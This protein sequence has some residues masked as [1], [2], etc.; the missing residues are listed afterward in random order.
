MSEPLSGLLQ[1]RMIL[2]GVAAR[3]EEKANEG[4]EARLLS[5][6]KADSIIDF[7][8]ALRDVASFFK[9]ASLC[10]KRQSPAG[11]AKLLEAIPEKVKKVEQHC[12]D[13]AK[14]IWLDPKKQE[15]FQAERDFFGR[16]FPSA[17]GQILRDFAACGFKSSDLTYH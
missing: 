4:C 7:Q 13:P 2:E 17:V 6:I 1:A 8:D 10:L 14:E 12:V 15:F 3:L 9:A 5:R 16:E 11:A